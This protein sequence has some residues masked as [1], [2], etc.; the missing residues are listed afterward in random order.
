VTSSEQLPAT[1]VGPDRRGRWLSALW[2][3]AL[4]LVP[5][6][7]VAR[8]GDHGAVILGLGV[9]VAAVVFAALV[10]HRPTV[11]TRDEVRHPKRAIRR[12]DVARV[13]R[14]EET[15]ALVF[16]G[17]DGGVVAIIDVFEQ[18]GKLRE[19]LRAHGWPVGDATG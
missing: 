4:V 11:V 13:T 9:V 14:S 19:A 12:A 8:L 1:E 5:A 7:V 17:V 6:L 18:S 16:H 2:W 10:R 3:S 15:T